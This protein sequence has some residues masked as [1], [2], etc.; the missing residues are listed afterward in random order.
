MVK[1]L[2]IAL[3]ET[4]YATLKKAKGDMSWHDFVMQLAGEPHVRFNL[5]PTTGK[6][7]KQ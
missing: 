6:K 3:E 2:N 1:T 4:E 5:D 7:T